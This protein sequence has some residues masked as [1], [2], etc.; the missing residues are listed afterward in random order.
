MK[1]RSVPVIVV[2][3]ILLVVLSVASVAV[4]F[5]FPQMSYL[6]KFIIPVMAV[7]TLVL[8]VAWIVISRNLT[9]YATRMDKD[10]VNVGRE[11]FYD[12]PEPIVIVDETEKVVWYNASFE[13][14]IFDQDRAYGINFCDLVGNNTSKVYA[15]GG[16]I[17]KILDHYYRVSARKSDVFNLSVVSFIDETE[18]VLL[19]NEFKASRKTV[20]IM[21]V[22]NY[23]DVVQNSKESGKAHVQVQI[24]QMF[25][26]F[27]ENTNG[28]IHKVS[29]DRFYAIIEERHLSP[30]IERRFDILDE[31]RSIIVGE[32]M[33][34]TLSIGVG[35]GAKTLAESEAYAKQA[36]DMCLGRGGDQ[37]AVKTEN[38]FEFFGGI[39]K[40]VEKSTKVKSRI[41]A[42]ALKELAQN[43]S[44]VFIMGHRFAD[45][46]AVGAS[47]G[48][49]GA[50]RSMGKKAYV[51]VDPDKNLAKNLIEHISTNCSPDYFVRPEQAISML[52]DKSLLIVVDTHNPD[53]VDSRELYEATKQVV[54]IDHHRKTV[55]YIDNAVVFFHEPFASSTC[56]MAAELIQYFG[57]ECKISISEAEA[58][59]AGI[60]LDTKN[61]V[62]R[63]N[64]RTFEAA[65]YLKRLGADTVV[66]KGFFS[67]SFETYMERSKLMQNA[68]LF[69][70]CAIAV[71]DTASP[72]IR[73]AAPQ[74][75]DE[76]LGITG[77][78]A[79]FVLYRMDGVC[80]ISARSMGAFNCQLIMES[81]AGGGHG[82]GHRTMAGGQLDMS[83]EEAL[84]CLKET[85]MD[86]LVK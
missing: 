35:R 76:L 33:S 82:G 26:H 27:I 32:R 16:A 45:F 28:V 83:N 36:L 58:L 54:V 19:D 40:A 53:Y 52:D 59:L 66:V 73:L 84:A 43:S 44:S 12:Y 68:E 24:E 8:A 47:I 57:N 14:H 69:H 38:G 63:S 85:I 34:V 81:I 9:K 70:G 62:M 29:N 5:A 25:E 51:A 39:S 21:T 55:N 6:L 46:D 78:K 3:M 41:I 75:A 18:H 50:L 13:A 72:A 67:D 80:N 74:A 31:A 17:V 11:T 71:T 4:S 86:F 7:C 56:E 60:T 49:C 37:A 42:T 48:L 61:F 2:P 15:P 20:L 10:I 23:E 77:V 1:K 79:S 30:I 64:A 65:A 22:D